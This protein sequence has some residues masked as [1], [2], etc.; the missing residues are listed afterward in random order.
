[1]AR[2]GKSY[3]E[4]KRDM[5]S[6]LEIELGI[7]ED[8]GYGRFTREPRQPRSLFQHSVS[9]INHWVDPEHRPDSC[10]GCILLDFVP[11]EHKENEMPCHCIPLNRSGETVGSLEMAG[12]QERLE[13]AVADWLRTT[14]RQLKAEFG[15]EQSPSPEA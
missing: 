14:I 11:P 3:A 15:S 13:N 8:G 12:D 5:I 10:E 9:C 2:P 7:V 6:L 1:M 4:D